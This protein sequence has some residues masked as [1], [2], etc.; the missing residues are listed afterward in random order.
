MD[1]GYIAVIGGSFALLG[2]VAIMSYMLGRIHERNEWE[3]PQ[4]RVEQ[5]DDI[6]NDWYK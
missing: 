1:V 5:S 6:P 2:L 3:G 4:P